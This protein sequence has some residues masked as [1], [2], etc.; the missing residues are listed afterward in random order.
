MISLKV[1]MI[2][3]F[4]KGVTQHR[5]PDRY[6]SRHALIFHGSDKPLC[7]SVQIRRARRHLNQLDTLAGEKYPECQRILR[8]PIDNLM[9]LSEEHPG[10]TE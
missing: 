10:L 4:A 6:Q 7:V 2:R 3:I 9:P 5:C 1:V 8:V